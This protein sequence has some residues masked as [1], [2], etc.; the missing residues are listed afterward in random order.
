MRV[1][2]M[3]VLLAATGA[4]AFE[5]K[6]P[7]DF[8]TAVPSALD[9]PIDREAMASLLE[10]RE[11]EIAELRQKL[12]EVEE[13]GWYEEAV[14]LGVAQAVARSHLPE[15]SQRRI[16]AAI[17]REARKNNVDPLLVVAV[18]RT[19]SAFNTWAV[20]PVGAMGLMQVMP[21]T[22][23]WLAERRGE[24]MRRTENLFDSE[25]NIELG[26]MYLAELIEEFGTIEKALVAYNAGPGNAKKIL[27]GRP[28]FRKRFL[29][30]YPAKV[31]GD[32][33]K[34]RASYERTA[35]LA[36]SA[37]GDSSSSL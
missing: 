12:A 15:R 17:V 6:V 35:K 28:E 36:Q 4:L 7:A 13:L 2:A 1:V 32:F 3:T 8:V 20:S 33:K 27:N 19:E 22:G 37:A 34:L 10:K 26:T 11:K 29:A 18:I 16:S 31:V 21:N 14:T 24:K 25:Y 9:G 30:G 5:A 23:K